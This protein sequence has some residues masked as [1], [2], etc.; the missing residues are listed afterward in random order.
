MSLIRYE[1]ETRSQTL[2]RLLD[3]N[4]SLFDTAKTSIDFESAGKARVKLMYDI[5]NRGI[6]KG[7]VACRRRIIFAEGMIGQVIFP[8]PP[9][10][11]RFEVDTRH[12]A[13]SH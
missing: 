10:R 13:P 8:L 5:D 1:S 11:E 9:R 4:T 3:E 6:A 7:T 12:R 2:R